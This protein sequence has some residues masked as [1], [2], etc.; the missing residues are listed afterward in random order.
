MVKSICKQ[1][2][3]IT[4]ERKEFVRWIIISAPFVIGTIFGFVFGI[5][6]KLLGFPFLMGSLFFGGL[7]YI[8]GFFYIVFSLQSSAVDKHFYVTLFGEG[9]GVIRAGSGL[10]LLPFGFYKI[11]EI[12]TE[13]I[14]AYFP[15]PEE[16]ISFSDDTTGIQPGMVKTYR[17]TTNNEDSKLINPV[18]VSEHE[19]KFKERII[20]LNTIINDSIQEKKSHS[21]KKPD[22][23]KERMTL[24]PRFLVKFKPTNIEEDDLTLDS[25]RRFFEKFT[26]LD[27]LTNAIGVTTLDILANIFGKLTPGML[28]EHQEV[29]SKII[30]L[31]LKSIFEPKGV[32][33]THFGLINLGLPKTISQEI[34]NAA[35]ALSQKSTVITAAEAARESKILAAQATE[36]EKILVG[37]GEAAA[38]KAVNT[39]DME[40]LEKEAQIAADAEKLLLFAKAKGTKEF[41]KALGLTGKEASLIPILETI[42]KGMK[43]N[44]LNIIAGGNSDIEQIIKLAATKLS[45][46]NS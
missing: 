5:I 7:F 6:T 9:V 3:K 43:D 30:T 36:Q 18:D 28:V 25:A 26:S 13:I 40:R 20:D 8:L 2:K 42:E 29:I 38:K 44:N 19:K 15:A 11:Q 31:R 46:K 37:R 32:H 14:E 41:A 34:R 27:D 33:V 39:V 17:I 1:N 12:N 35:A 16:R 10:F 21:S 24:E 45:K 22:P 4:M 23:L